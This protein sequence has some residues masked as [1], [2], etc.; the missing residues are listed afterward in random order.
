MPL[1]S[2]ASLAEAGEVSNPFANAAAADQASSSNTGLALAQALGFQLRVWCERLDGG[3]S[4][5]HAV[6]VLCDTPLEAYLQH[7]LCLHA[8][9]DPLSGCGIGT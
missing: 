7:V 8:A 2:S 1:S 6:R 9:S 3:A 4:R 5:E